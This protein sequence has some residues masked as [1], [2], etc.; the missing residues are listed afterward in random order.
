MRYPLNIILSYVNINSIRNKFT[1]L[2]FLIRDYFDI[3]TIAETKLDQSFPSS[4]FAL[5]GYQFPPFRADFKADSGGLLTFVKNDIPARQLDQFKFDP[6]V[7]VITI[8]L[9]IKKEKWLIND[10]LRDRL[11]SFYFYSNR[12]CC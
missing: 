10:F 3:I 2:G 7:Q 12:P 9:N 6:S 5:A 4:E 11:T 1:D 8:E